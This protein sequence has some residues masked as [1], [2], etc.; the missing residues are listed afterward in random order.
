MGRYAV[1]FHWNDGHRSG[2]FSWDYLRRHCNCEECRR[3]SAQVE[4][5]AK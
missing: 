3:L 5:A 1:S 2:I 4:T